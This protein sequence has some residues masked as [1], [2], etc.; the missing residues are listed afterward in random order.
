ME[1][2]SIPV[3]SDTEQDQI[4]E[5]FSSPLVKKY[6]RF[7]GQSIIKDIVE[8]APADHQSDSEYIRKEAHY[9]GRLAAI[10]TLLSI[11]PRN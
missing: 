10:E 1:S 11:Q 3:I 6:L 9:K 8:G 7:L 5:I 4:L 2:I